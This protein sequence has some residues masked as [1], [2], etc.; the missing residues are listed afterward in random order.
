MSEL[1]QA[2]GHSAPAVTDMAKKLA[3]RGLVEYIPYRGVR[4]TAAGRRE[5]TKALRRHRIVE[6]LLTDMLGFPWQEAHELA[7]KFEHELPDRV[8]ERLFRVLHNPTTCPHGFPIPEVPEESFPKVIT[9]SRLEEGETS[10]VATVLEEG[11]DILDFIDS[12]GLRPGSRVTVL[13]KTPFDGPLVLLV[14]DMERTIG[15]NLAQIITVQPLDARST[16]AAGEGGRET[17]AEWVPGVGDT[18]SPAHA[19]LSSTAVQ[20]E[21]A[22]GSRD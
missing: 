22:E 1:A 13:R 11:R 7:V 19:G 17:T 15:Y 6:R 21:A 10:E 14:D 12:L 16:G 3:D 20:L 18:S 9:L 2:M 5:A 8:E 4:L